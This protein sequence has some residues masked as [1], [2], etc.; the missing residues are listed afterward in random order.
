MSRHATVVSRGPYIEATVDGDW[1]PGQT[2]QGAQTLAVS[3][4]AP[5]WIPVDTLE[6]LQNGEVIETV[7]LTGE[8]PTWGE[9]SFTLNPDADAVYEVIAS[10][11]RSMSDGPWA[12]KT[13]W[14]MTAAIRVDIDGDGWEAPS[15]PLTIE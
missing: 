6:L 4:W 3:V 9:H 5:S 8:A 2:Y 14:A 12:G 11:S 7:T 10:N 1:A 15:P 13:P